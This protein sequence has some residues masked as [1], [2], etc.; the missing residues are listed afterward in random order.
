[1]KASIRIECRYADCHY[2]KCLIFQCYAECRYAECY[3]AVRPLS[4]LLS[5]NCLKILKGTNA[6]AYSDGE[7]GEKVFKHLNLVDGHHLLSQTR[8]S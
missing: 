6:L 5:K 4:C 3:Y 1:M 8:F 7:E 2:A